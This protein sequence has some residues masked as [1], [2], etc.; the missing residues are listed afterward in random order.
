[1]GSF[2]NPTSLRSV[3]ELDLDTG[4]GASPGSTDASSDLTGPATRAWLEHFRLVTDMC[5]ISQQAPT[6]IPIQS[7]QRAEQA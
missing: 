6:R 7:G 5:P 1:M 2:R 3:Y 4:E